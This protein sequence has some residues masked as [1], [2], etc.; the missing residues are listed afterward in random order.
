[1]KEKYEET[2]HEIMTNMIL[3]PDWI[4]DFVVGMLLF[5]VPFII[6]SGILLMVEKRSEYIKIG[7][8]FP[9]YLFVA[10]GCFLFSTALGL[11]YAI[12]PLNNYLFDV[13]GGI[14]GYI[15]FIEEFIVFGLGSIPLLLICNELFVV[16]ARGKY[17]K[18]LHVLLLYIGNFLMLQALRRYL[19][20]GL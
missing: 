1:M 4:V 7:K 16:V 2:L 9:I 11:R 19:L 5:Y 14:M 3:L 10:P 8:L 15:G 20:I 13:R 12:E 6:L 17:G 18:Y